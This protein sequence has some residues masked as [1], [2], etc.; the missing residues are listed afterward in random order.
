MITTKQADRL[1]KSGEVV[2]IRE[3]NYPDSGIFS[4]RIICRD[5]WTVTLSDSAK[6]SR[7]EL[8]IINL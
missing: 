8:E 1:I 3:I 4:V 6:I 5:R 7:D 2:K